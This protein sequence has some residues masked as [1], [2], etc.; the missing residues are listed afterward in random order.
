MICKLLFVLMG[1]V[2]LQALLV[3]L[4]IAQDA[5]KRWVWIKSGGSG[6]WDLHKYESRQVN[7]KASF[8]DLD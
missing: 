2:C 7:A 1:I 5:F 4:I 6:D 8:K 3:I